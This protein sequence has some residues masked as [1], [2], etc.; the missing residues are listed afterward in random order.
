M[1]PPV[2]LDGPEGRRIAYHRTEGQTP[3]IVFLPGYRS[4]MEGTKALHLEAW[5]QAKGHAFLRFDYSGHGQSEGTMLDTGPQDWSADALAV[6]D[7]LTTGPQ[8]LV[9]SSMGGWMALLAARRRPERVAGLV[10]IAAAPDFI[11]ESRLPDLTPAQ[12][13]ALQTEGRALLSEDHFDSPDYL[14]QHQVDGAR[15]NLVFAQA[16]GL[17]GPVRFLQG[18]QDDAVTRDTALKLLDHAEGPDIQLSLVKGA[19]HRFS[20]AACLGHIVSAVEDVLAA[21]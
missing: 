14:T 5:A 20:T 12:R 11:T 9:G 2:T 4:D 17:Q 1:K 13:T 21:L 16:W 10:T 8:I 7:E 6:L 15:A 3:G 19:D 18:T